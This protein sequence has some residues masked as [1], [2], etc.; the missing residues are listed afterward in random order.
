MQFV[1]HQPGSVVR[2]PRTTESR[3]SVPVTRSFHHPVR[4]LLVA[5]PG[6]QWGRV[7]PYLR[8]VVLEHE[9]GH[10]AD[11]IAGVVGVV[12]RAKENQADCDAGA[13]TK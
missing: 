6:G 10:R 7:A 2:R 3:R 12:S 5:G 8:V 11:A 9:L 13:T 4:L 1:Q